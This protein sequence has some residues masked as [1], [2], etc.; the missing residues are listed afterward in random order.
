MATSPTKGNY[1]IELDGRWSL[2]DFSRFGNEYL[3][4]YAFFYAIEA[5]S[6]AVVADELDSDGHVDYA[7]R[8]FPW[9]GGWSTVDFYNILA[10]AVPE[11]HRPR[12]IA[13]QYASPGYLDLGLWILAA[14]SLAKTV[15]IVAESL[16]SL[17]STYSN[18][19]KGMSERKLAKIDV[20]RAELTLKREE[21]AFAEDSA[22]QLAT[23]MGITS[24]DQLQG[25]SPNWLGTLKILMSLFRRIKPLA[26]LE[27]DAKLQLPER[28]SSDAPRIDAPSEEGRRLH[29]PSR[30]P[31]K[32]RS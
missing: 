28:S 18:I 20:R 24:L 11:E 17:N 23:G 8:A 25:L 30:K 5:K 4:A 10:H 12:I 26:L 21:L 13:I 3:Q 22:R 27:Q 15:K 2:Q 32:R 14:R 1:R 9:K 29:P 31:K 6:A 16:D 19:R 7:F